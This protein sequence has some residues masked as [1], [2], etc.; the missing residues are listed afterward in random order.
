MNF[1]KVVGTKIINA[2][3]LIFR[4]PVETQLRIKELKNDEA[5]EGSETLL[6]FES[7]TELKQYK[8]KVKLFIASIIVATI[9]TT[10]SLIFA[11]MLL[12]RFLANIFKH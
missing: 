4:N 7:Y 8:K 5:Y 3:Y 2:Y 9:L 6:S 10:V 1:F 11:F 12:V